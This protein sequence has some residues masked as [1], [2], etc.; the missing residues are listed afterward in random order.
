MMNNE[1]LTLY[2]YPDIVHVV[3]TRVESK[4]FREN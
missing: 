3:G 1:P 2:I 4:Q